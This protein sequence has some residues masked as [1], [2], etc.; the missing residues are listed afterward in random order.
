MAHDEMDSP[1]QS[2]RPPSPIKEEQINKENQDL[3][4]G[5]DASKGSN[6]KR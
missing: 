4:V 6:L 2:L 1:V 5:S 3:S